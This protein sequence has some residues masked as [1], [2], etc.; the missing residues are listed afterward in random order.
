MNSFFKTNLALACLGASLSI[1]TIAF[2]QDKEEI[3]ISAKGE[4]TLQ[5]VLPTSHVF[6]LEDID[7]AQIKDIPALLESIPGVNLTDSGGRGSATGVFLRGNSGSQTIVLIDG[8]RVGSATLGSAAL[9]SFPVEAIERIEVIKGPFSGI[10]GADAVGGVIQLFTKKSGEGLGIASASVG[11]DGLTEYSLGFNGG[12]ERNGFHV[13]IY[14]EDTDGI[15]RTSLTNDGND[16]EDGF[17]ETA[18]SFGGTATLSDKVVANLNVLYSDNTTVFD[19]TFDSDPDL[20]S[21]DTG[22]QTE[23]TLLS[24]ALNVTAQL[25]DSLVWTSTLGIN[26]D[27]SITDAFL[28]DITTE[29]NSIGTELAYSFGGENLLTVGVEYFDEEVETLSDFPETERDNSAVYAQLQTGTGDLSFVGS[30]RYDDN[31]VYGDDTNVSLAVNY[32]F[33]DSIRATASYGTAFVAPSF[34]QLFFPFFGNPDVEPEESDSYELTLRGNH[35]NVDWRASVYKTDVTNLIAFDIS[36][37]LAG[38]IGEAEFEGL[39]LE[40]GTQVADWDVSAA[41]DFLSADNAITGEQLNDRAEQTIRLTAA[42]DFG[43]FDLRFDVR[44]EDG[45]VDAGD[46]DLSSY[47]LFDISGRYKINDQWSVLA[48]IDNVFDK[49]Y[50]VNLINATERF[51]TEGTQAKL[52]VRYNF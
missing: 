5:N 25:N 37:F 30:V 23:N 52:T 43:Q 20:E 19:S 14:Q 34:N 41:L 26:E 28:S 24:T 47:V 7:V 35:A 46:I 36:T 15:D 13:S 50:T 18:I 42:R 45:R 38:N 8:V 17:E 33:N 3:V 12:N 29:R 27:E 9:N 10:Y 31:S 32:D 2:S 49:D 4:Q 40:I 11:N 16:D 1:P 51:N 21:D 48:N 44:G 22:F 39:E 6:T